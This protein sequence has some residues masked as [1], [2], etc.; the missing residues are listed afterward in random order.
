VWPD[1]T[2]DAYRF[3]SKLY[4]LPE[5]VQSIKN[6][7][8][9]E[10]FKERWMVEDVHALRGSSAKGT[11][12]FGRNLGVWEGI[13]TTLNVEWIKIS[14]KEWQKEYE[15]TV[16][17]KERKNKLKI[18]AQRYVDNSKSTFNVT[19]ANADAILIAK[20]YKRK[21]RNYGTNTD[22]KKNSNR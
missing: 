10:G 7:C 5:I 14:P 9:V 2:I 8:Y 4:K 16:Q 11:F 12:T 6:H 13:L 15:L 21:G 22:R 17:G 1:R 3:P 20:Y 19:F 18:F